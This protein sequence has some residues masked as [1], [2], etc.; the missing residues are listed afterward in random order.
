[1]PDTTADTDTQTEV[2]G[3]VV[4]EP[5][6][7][8]QGT[9]ALVVTYTDFL[10]QASHSSLFQDPGRYLLVRV[11]H[12]SESDDDLTEVTGEQVSESFV[13]DTDVTGIEVTH[14]NLKTDEVNTRQFTEPGVYK[15]VRTGDE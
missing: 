11:P 13:D 10:D 3:E 14:I 2:T 8:D 6:L 4:A 5:F 12:T 15:T 7:S 1:M 9:M